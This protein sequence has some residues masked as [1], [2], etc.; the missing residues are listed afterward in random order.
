MSNLKTWVAGFGLIGLGALAGLVVPQPDRIVFLNVGQG[1]S[2]LIQSEGVNVLVDT[3]P[4]DNFTDAGEKLVVPKLKSLGVNGVD[5]VVLTHPDM[6]HIGGTG[7]VLKSFPNARLAISESFRDNHQ[8]LTQLTSW[9]IS[10][11]RVLW[12][13]SEL[14][15]QLG[16]FKFRLECP[17]TAP[18]QETNDGSIVMRISDGAASAVLMGDAPIQSEQVMIP[19]GDWKAE[20][21]KV[22]HH[23]SHS[24]SSEAWIRAVHP[25]FAIVSCGRNNR[26]GHPHREVIDR[27]TQNQVT[28]FRTDRDGDIEFDDIGGRFVKD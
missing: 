28:I 4:K 18:D 8:L 2:T 22:G 20:L 21:L 23:G 27:L 11:E 19:L 6:D 15:G 24:S 7:S 10:T 26:Y 5:L 1:D 16:R 9:N 25:E 14:E 12:L 17:K 13:N 3:G